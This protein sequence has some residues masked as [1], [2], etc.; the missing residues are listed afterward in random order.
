[1]N[2]I[3]IPKEDRKR[4]K[5]LLKAIADLLLHFTIDELQELHDKIEELKTD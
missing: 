4:F 3:H 1:M 5:E 2:L